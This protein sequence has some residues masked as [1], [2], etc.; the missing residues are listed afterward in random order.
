[1]GNNNWVL[2]ILGAVVG[3]AAGGVLVYSIMK[4]REERLQAEY[5]QAIAKQDSYIQSLERRLS[6]LEN[7][8]LQFGDLQ[9]QHGNLDRAYE[10]VI[11][12]IENLESQVT[13]PDTKLRLKEMKE[14]ARRK[15]QEQLVFS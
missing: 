4:S 5:R 9:L 11:T 8:K 2:P 12:D 13:D 15:K 14:R 3:M 1:M 6:D 7:V 10:D